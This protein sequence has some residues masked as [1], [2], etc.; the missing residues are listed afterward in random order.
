[1]NND[2]DGWR[3]GATSRVQ[4]GNDAEII[5]RWSRDTEYHRLGDNDPAYPQSVKWAR[6]W[7]DRDSDR[8]L[9]LCHPHP[10]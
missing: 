9:R 2:S 6:E 1:M 5:A 3:A 7:L 4:S 8:S 10:E